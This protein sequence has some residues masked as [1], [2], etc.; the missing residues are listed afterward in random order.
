M[1]GIQVG[2]PLDPKVRREEILKG[3]SGKG[4]KQFVKLLYD[5]EYTT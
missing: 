3:P 5:I 2:L 4:N 1:G